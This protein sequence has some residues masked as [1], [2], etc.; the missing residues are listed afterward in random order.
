MT[1]PDRP[2]LVDVVDRLFDRGVVVR[3]ELWLTVADIELVFI[4]A[5]LVIAPADRMS[6]ARTPIKEHPA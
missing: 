3:G 5:D 4:G 6:A 1:A 2:R